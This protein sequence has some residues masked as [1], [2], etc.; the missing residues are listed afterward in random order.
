MRR[1]LGILSLQIRRSRLER[2]RRST[3]Q[4]DEL[5]ALHGCPLLSLR[6]GHYHTV[7]EERRCASQQKLRDDVADGQAPAWK[8][9]PLHD[10]SSTESGSPSAIL[11]CRISATSRPEQVRQTEQA[12]SITSSARASSVGGTSR[13]SAFAVVRLTTNSNLVGCSTGMSLGFAPR[14]IL[15]TSSA[16]RLNKCGMFAP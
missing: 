10:R 11:L 13:P 7:A 3:E 8:R 12:Y 14:R 4:G 5:A 15:S 9:C 2:P 16:A 6:A 1:I